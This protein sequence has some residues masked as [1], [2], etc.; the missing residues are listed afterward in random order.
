MLF[1]ENSLSGVQYVDPLISQ[2][3][4]DYSDCE[5]E[6]SGNA[7]EL[8][9]MGGAGEENTND[10]ILEDIWKSDEDTMKFGEVENKTNAVVVGKVQNGM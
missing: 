5:R 7:I 10:M 6:R 8:N 1:T 9:P 2:E 4:I 3:F